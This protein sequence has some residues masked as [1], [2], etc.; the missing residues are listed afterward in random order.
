MSRRT[1]GEKSYGPVKK[2]NWGNGYQI[3]KSRPSKRVNCGVCK[4]YCEE[5]TCKKSNVSVSQLGYNF[6]KSCKYFFVD[7]EYL[8]EV[9]ISYIK[10]MRD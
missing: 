8:S 5:G 3:E 1:R 2:G 9:N 7:D 4:Y 10:R 6:W